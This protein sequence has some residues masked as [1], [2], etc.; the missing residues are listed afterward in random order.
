MEEEKE[1]DA[2]PYLERALSVDPDNTEAQSLLFQIQSKPPP[3][4]W[5][6]RNYN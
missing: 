4:V 6:S 2:V 3:I 1:S 5:V